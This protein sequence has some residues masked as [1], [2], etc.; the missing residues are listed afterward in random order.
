[1]VWGEDCY[2]NYSLLAHT[3]ESLP[4]EEAFDM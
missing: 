3:K 1:M 4:M 2:S